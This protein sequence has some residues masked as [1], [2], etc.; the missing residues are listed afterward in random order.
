[1]YQWIRSS[2]T[3]LSFYF[4]DGFLC[5]VKTFYFDVLAFIYFFSFVF[6]AWGGVSDKILP[7]QSK[8]LLLMFSSTIFMVSG[9]TFQSLIH[10]E[11]ILLCALRSWSNFIFLHISVQFLPTPFIEWTIFRTLYVLA[12]LSNINLL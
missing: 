4:V 3:W 2:I 5:C 1:M 9:L 12:S 10:S 6:L 7:E 8:I 11:S